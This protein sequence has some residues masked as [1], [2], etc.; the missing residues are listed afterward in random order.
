MCRQIVNFT[1]TG[2]SRHRTSRAF[3]PRGW[4]KEGERVELVNGEFVHPS[5]KL[6]PP[7]RFVPVV[8]SRSS[9]PEGAWG[10]TTIGSGSSSSVITI[11]GGGGGINR[12]RSKR[13][14]SS[15]RHHKGGAKGFSD[16]GDGKK[17]MSGDGGGTGRSSDANLRSA[18]RDLEK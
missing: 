12:P 3:L 4:T 15:R 17:R 6:R 5:R 16:I 2:Y 10:Y 9:S 1:Y 8:P 18:R 7:P 14:S 11:R 13:G